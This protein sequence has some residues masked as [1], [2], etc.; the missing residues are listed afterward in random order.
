MVE[1]R[2]IFDNFFE[3]RR[4]KIS[5]LLEFPVSVNIYSRLSLVE[6]G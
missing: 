4:I 6:T 5:C 1:G 3:R 2:K